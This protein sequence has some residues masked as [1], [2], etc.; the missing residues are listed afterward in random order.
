MPAERQREVWRAVGEPG[1]V[2]LDGRIAGTWR[3]RKRG[4][5]L[6]LTVTAFGRL[7]KAERAA[8]VGEAESIAPLR[9]AA[10]VDVEFAG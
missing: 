10:T 9:G 8:I 7:T 3:P 6:T 1:T 4:K 2:L 5:R